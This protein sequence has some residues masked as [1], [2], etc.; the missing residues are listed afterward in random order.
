MR[1]T[2]CG[3]KQKMNW[4]ASIKRVDVIQLL[5]DQQVACLSDY[6][7]SLSQVSIK[8]QMF[9]WW[10]R[11]KNYA[12]SCTPNFTVYEDKRF[13][14]NRKTLPLAR[15]VFGLGEI[16]IFLTRKLVYKNWCSLN[17][18]VAEAAHSNKLLAIDPQHSAIPLRNISILIYL[19]SRHRLNKTK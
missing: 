3:R 15:S 13:G 14:Q 5:S 8:F 6:R 10:D 4:N 18:L 1:C 9:Y 11:F 2:T 7:A 16:I 12:C 17:R 19:H